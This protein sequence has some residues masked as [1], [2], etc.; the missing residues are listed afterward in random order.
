M[1]LWGKLG[2]KLQELTGAGLY[3]TGISAHFHASFWGKLRNYTPFYAESA[4]VLLKH[5]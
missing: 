4:K 5:R 3:I 1:I 2:G